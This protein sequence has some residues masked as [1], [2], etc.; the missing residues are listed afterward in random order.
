MRAYLKY[1]QVDLCVPPI[2]LEKIHK[3][4]ISV[5]CSIL[6]QILETDEK[7]NLSSKEHSNFNFKSTT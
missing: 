4:H 6:G 1:F 5:L 7:C 2:R 3:I